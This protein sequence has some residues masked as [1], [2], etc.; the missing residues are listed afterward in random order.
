MSREEGT[1]RTEK[2]RRREGRDAH[3]VFISQRCLELTLERFPFVLTQEHHLGKTLISQ[4]FLLGANGFLFPRLKMLKDFFFLSKMQ[5]VSNKT[6]DFSKAGWWGNILNLLA[7]ESKLPSVTY[8]N[9]NV[10]NRSDK[11]IPVYF[12]LVFQSSCR[13]S[14]ASQLPLLGSVTHFP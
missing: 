7:H 6:T 3:T 14:R 8:H 2:A 10:Q 1:Q 9:P 11:T 12:I 4:S 5:H 13:F